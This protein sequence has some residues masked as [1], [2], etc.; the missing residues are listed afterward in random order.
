MSNSLDYFWETQETTAN[1]GAKGCRAG[2]CKCIASTTTTTTATTAT[3]ITTT[4]ITTTTYTTGKCHGVIEDP[5]C[6]TLDGIPHSHCYHELLFKQIQAETNC[7]IMCNKCSS[8]TTTSYTQTSTTASST[9]SITQTSTTVTT[10]LFDIAGSSNTSTPSALYPSIGAIGGLLLVAAVVYTV[11]RSFRRQQ[12]AKTSLEEA[13]QKLNI[14]DDCGCKLC[15]GS[16]VAGGAAAEPTASYVVS[17]VDEGKIVI[18]TTDHVEFLIP[19]EHTSLSVANPGFVGIVLDGDAGSSSTTDTPVP[20]RALAPPT[21]TPSPS[22]TSKLDKFVAPV[23][24]LGENTLAAIGLTSIMGVDPKTFRDLKGERAI[25]KMV[26]EFKKSGTLWPGDEQS[27][28]QNIAGLINGSYCNP[29]TTTPLPSLAEL[30]QT[31]EVVR[32]K[33][34]GLQSHHVLAIRL[35]TTSSYRSINSPMRQKPHAQL[36][37]PFAATMY[38]IT[39]GLKI[40]R[41]AQGEDTVNA[42]KEQ[43]FYRGLRDLQI[44]TKFMEMGGTEMSCM[45]TTLDINVAAAFASDC[46]SPLLFRYLSNDFMSSGARI[47][48][49]SVYPEEKEVLY[50][51]LTYLSCP[52][53]GSVCEVVINGRTYPVVEVRPTYPE[54]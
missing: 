28:E 19:M 5:S 15:S 49:I 46:T 9:T 35:Y 31:I 29:G 48:F 16:A 12:R 25:K 22:P 40:L 32:L 27:D 17:Q 7:P 14:P 4:T 10:H 45:S 47:W 3:T 50:P 52:T 41:A 39:T 20:A 26:S 51:P 30:M 1:E 37:H 38:Y 36:P 43:C 13:K 21:I 54:T 42:S 8:T 34:H 53:A 11:R 33:K 2:G 24:V 23:M 6:G 44:S 18:T